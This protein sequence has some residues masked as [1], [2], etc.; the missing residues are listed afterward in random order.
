VTAAGDARSAGW[1][2]AVR[3]SVGTLTVLPAPAPRRLDRTVA[4]RAMLLAPL[5]GGLLGFV[6][7]GVLFLARRAYHEPLLPS[8]LAIATLAVLTR[9]LHLDGLADTADALGVG[10][11]RGRDRALEVMRAGD[12]GPFGVA[13]VALVLL[14]EV[15]A[16]SDAVLHGLGTESIIGAAIV[17]RLAVTHACLRGVPSARRDGLGATVA[18]SV[19]WAG[20]AVVT[21]LVVAGG[22]LEGGVLDDDAGTR[23]AL[24]AALS[25]AAGLAAAWLVVVVAR[26]RFGGITGDVLGACVEVATTATLLV[27]AAWPWVT[28][29]G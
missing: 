28:F 29:P 22:L 14:V 24:L 4:G 8:V 21:V 16:L 6:A 11:H 2:D 18:G 27:L 10:A 15:T 26:R 9:G 7:A 12:V 13:A 20:A 3:L 23:P 19:P 1:L 17:G 5:V 25:V